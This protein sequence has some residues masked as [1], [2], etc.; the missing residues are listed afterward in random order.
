MDSTR[1]ILIIEIYNLYE[2]IIIKYKNIL[3]IDF[4]EM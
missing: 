3:M 4:H 2:I 1:L